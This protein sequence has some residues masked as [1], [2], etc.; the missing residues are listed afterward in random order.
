MRLIL[1]VYACRGGLEF[2]VDSVLDHVY[3]EHS[4]DR[5]E[6]LYHRIVNVEELLIRLAESEAPVKVLIVDSIAYMF[7][8]LDPK[9]MATALSIRSSFFFKI[10]FLL[11]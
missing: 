6:D 10:A 7:R 11:R 8:D 5:E 4:F 2:S 3:M 9:A 1:G